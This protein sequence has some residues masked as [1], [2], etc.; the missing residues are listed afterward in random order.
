[1]RQ[2]RH[3]KEF[4]KILQEI[5]SWRRQMSRM[6]DSQLSGLTLSFKE[7]L[8][9]G[10]S[11]DSL[12]PQAY[13]AICEADFRILGKFPYDVQIIGAIALHKGM[14]AEMNT[15]EGKTLAATMPLY[16]NAL[17]EKSAILLTTNDY[18]ALRD[19]DEMGRVYRFMGLSVAAGASRRTDK[20]FTNEDKKRIYAS[21]IVYTTH[22]GLGFDYLI[23]NLVTTAEDRFLREFYYVIIDEA[24]T[25]L[26]D[27][28]QTAVQPV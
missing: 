26:L 6:T 8:R 14:L 18:L 22:G 13:A 16:L 3:L 17:T 7:R 5:K 27:S 4:N 20:P 19:A 12:L 2:K 25:V 21:D 28:A 24:D 10:E 11:L 9:R 23:N 15:G 1:M